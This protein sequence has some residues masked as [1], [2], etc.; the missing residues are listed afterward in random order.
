MSSLI[1]ISMTHAYDRQRTTLNSPGSSALLL[2]TQRLTSL[3]TTSYYSSMYSEHF[4]GR[5]SRLRW[6][7]GSKNSCL[8]VLGGPGPGHTLT[9]NSAGNHPGKLLYLKLLIAICRMISRTPACHEPSST[10]LEA[11]STLLNSRKE[12]WTHVV[13]KFGTRFPSKVTHCLLTKI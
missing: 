6:F 4:H 8:T 12:T 13:S 5:S 11:L 10:L 7:L 2:V 1:I 3:V 9:G